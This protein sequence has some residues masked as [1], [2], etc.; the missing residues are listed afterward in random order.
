VATNVDKVIQGLVDY[1]P[2]GTEGIKELPEEFNGFFTN[3]SP[4]SK[5]P[6][7]YITM[8]THSFLSDNEVLHMLLSKKSSLLKDNREDIINAASKNL[9]EKIKTFSFAGEEVKQKINR[10]NSNIVYYQNKIKES[11]KKEETINKNIDTIAKDLNV[12]RVEKPTSKETSTGDFNAEIDNVFGETAPPEENSSITLNNQTQETMKILNTS[13]KDL[14]KYSEGSIRD[15][16]YGTLSGSYLNSVMEMTRLISIGTPQAMALA[17]EAQ[18]KAGIKQYYMDKLNYADSFFSSIDDKNTKLRNDELAMS[19]YSIYDEVFRSNTESERL[20]AVN[21]SYPAI[22]QL[23]Q[24]L[25]VLDSGKQ[26]TT[27]SQADAI[28]ELVLARLKESDRGE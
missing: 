2:E 5:I 24:A 12:E 21:A 17:G 6:S 7:P 4:S 8:N 11:E 9:K 18:K 19:G 16:L 27:L 23:R 15:Q 1:I 13:V 26:D 22:V 10:L 3:D 28:V 20:K 14:I 25:Q